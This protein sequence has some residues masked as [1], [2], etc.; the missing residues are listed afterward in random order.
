MHF[1]RIFAFLHG[2][3]P[4]FADTV[5]LCGFGKVAQPDAHVHP[6]VIAEL[7]QSIHIHH[8]FSFASAT[9]KNDDSNGNGI[10]GC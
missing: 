3:P 9:R 8:G 6:V 1:C 10:G 2:E 4:C 5:Q 7:H